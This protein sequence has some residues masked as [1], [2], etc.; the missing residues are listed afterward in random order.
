[1]LEETMP[2]PHDWREARRYRAW[3]LHRRGWTQRTI[4]TALGVT[5]GAVSQW[6]KRARATSLWIPATATT[7]SIVDTAPDGRL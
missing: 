7:Q 5:P 3:A 2:R 1:M 4:A 6:L